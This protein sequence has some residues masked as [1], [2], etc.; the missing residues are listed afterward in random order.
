MHATPATS[1][2]VASRCAYVGQHGQVDRQGV[3]QAAVVVQVRCKARSV[4][5]YNPGHVGRGAV[6]HVTCRHT[7]WLRWP[8]RG[9]QREAASSGTDSLHPTHV[10]PTVEAVESPCGRHDGVAGISKGHVGPDVRRQVRGDGC[11]RAIR[12]RKHAIPSCTPSISGRRIAVRTK[13]MCCKADGTLRQ[14]CTPRRPACCPCSPYMPGARYKRVGAGSCCR[15]EVLKMT[16]MDTTISTV[17][18]ITIQNHTT[19]LRTRFST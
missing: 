19:G 16:V 13:R 4:P 5:G 18:R 3:V 8:V 7:T 14:L 12:Q 15:S 10:S 2:T 9:K 11:S 6:Y 17:G 1:P